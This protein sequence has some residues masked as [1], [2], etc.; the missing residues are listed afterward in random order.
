MSIRRQALR[1]STVTQERCSEAP[2]GEE[3]VDRLPR[4]YDNP[5]ED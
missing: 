5:S 3:N 4:S 2:V 1:H